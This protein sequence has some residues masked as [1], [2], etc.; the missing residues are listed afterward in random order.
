MG[1]SF[2]KRGATF[3]YRCKAYLE[4]HGFFVIRSGGSHGIADLVAI[5]M[6]EVLM[7]QCKA[8][9]KALPPQEWNDLYRE[10][11]RVGATPIHAYKVG[12]KLKMM[13]IMGYRELREKGLTRDFLSSELSPLSGEPA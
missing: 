5:R 13:Q 6:G 9:N 2:Y 10:A 8:N 11:R 12:R 3:E 7:I 1:N 4:K